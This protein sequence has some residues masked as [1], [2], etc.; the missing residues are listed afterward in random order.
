MI[1]KI[2]IPTY[3]RPYKQITYDSLPQKWKEKSVLLTNETDTR[4]LTGLGYPAELCEAQ[5]SLARVRNW[6]QERA[7]GKYAVFDDDLN[8]FCYTARPSE[9][10]RYRLVNTPINGPRLEP[11]FEEYFDTFMD[12]MSEHLDQVV[13]CS[14]QTTWIPPF[15]EDYKEP[16]RMSGNHFYNADTFP[17]DLIDYEKIHCAEDFYYVLTLLT[18]GYPVR[19]DQR[20][21]VRPANT[22]EA[23]GCDTYRTIELHNESMLELQKM[24]PKYVTLK[25]KIA[26]VGA[27]GGVPKLAAN[28]QWKKALT[29]AR[30]KTEQTS[31]LSNFFD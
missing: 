9:R 3:N 21:R 2:Y 31:N 16:F 11:G 26:K 8:E 18:N 14:A 1:D 30:A 24:F 29:D 4:I 5:G 25:E 6:I 22:A 27:W 15:E 19:V 23:G 13:A 12:T 10:K 7:T 28:I 20:W 17:K